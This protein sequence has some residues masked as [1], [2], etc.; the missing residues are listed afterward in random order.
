[1]TVDPRRASIIAAL[2]LIPMIVLG[3]LAAFGIL[4]DGPA[5]LAMAV[6]AVL[7][8][9][10]ALFL[11]PVLGRSAAALLAVVLRLL[12]AGVLLIA[13]SRLSTGDRAGFESLWD[14]GLLLFGLHLVVAGLLFLVRRG[15]LVRIMGAFLGAAGVGYCVD[16][17]AALAVPGL[18]LGVAQVT[19]IGEILLIVWLLVR[20]GRPAA[21]APVP[22]PTVA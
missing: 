3:P 11:W 22:V 20:G 13:A 12:Y 4:D 14:A 9:V 15:V 10:V 2:A 6:V 19:F 16:A 5:G 17:I 18:D 7:D 21:V 8:V 1:M